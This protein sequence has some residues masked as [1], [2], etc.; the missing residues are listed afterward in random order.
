MNRTGKE[1]LVRYSS[2][3]DM[4][5]KTKGIV[6]RTVKYGETS[7]VVTMF[8]ELFGVQGY[9]VNGVRSASP[10]SPYRANFFQPAT[11]LDMVVYH[12]ERHALQ[13]VKEFK[14]SYI[15]EDIYRNI[16]KNTVALFITELLQKCLKQP[17]ANADLYAFVEDVLMHLD[18]GSATVAANMPL[19]F[20]LHQAHF[21]G[22]MIQDSYSEAQ[23]ILDLQE[24]G[25]VAQR[26]P[27]PYFIEGRLGEVSSQ[28]LKTMHPS[29]LEQLHLSREQRRAL[30]EAF[31][32]FYNFHQPDFGQMRSL[33]VLHALYEG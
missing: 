1:W 29:E 3:N 30:I 16:H 22:F 7:L 15:Y 27:H 14:W 31:I 8:T 4:L 20:M 28:L 18:K 6:L 17:E 25:F 21:F 23:T 11:L 9:M 33:S 13:R 2:L 24:G 10:R 26:P 19:Y 12:N 32:S 5:H